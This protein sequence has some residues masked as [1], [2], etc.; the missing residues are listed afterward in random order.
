MET[1]HTETTEGFYYKIL[2]GLLI[3][4]A[5]TFVQPTMFLTES[6]VGAQLLI[7]AIKAWLIVMFYMHLKGEKL[8]GSLVLGTLFIV[9]FFF[10][11]VGIDVTSFQYAD[12]STITDTA[13]AAAPSAHTDVNAVTDTAAHAVHH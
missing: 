7:A 9:A 5:I 13:A 3:L 8:I 6:T 2:A 4:T 10:L 11:V 1:N 12:M